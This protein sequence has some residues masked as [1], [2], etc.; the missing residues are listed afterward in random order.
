[1]QLTIA[2]MNLQS[3]VATTK[4]GWHYALSGWKYWLPHSDWP[5]RA[6]GKML[7]EENVDIACITEISEKSLC[8]G[9][10]SQVDILSKSAEIDN[11]CFFSTKVPFDTLRD[12]GNAIFSKH[13]IISSVS[14][15]LHKELFGASLDEAIIE[16]ENPQGQSAKKISVLVAHLALT[17]KNREIQIKEIIEILKGKEGLIILAG[18]FN[19]RN[20]SALDIL[21]KE[22]P[23]KNKC[24]LPTFPSWNPKQSFDYIFLSKE[25]SVT[26]CHIQ[27][28][29]P[30]SDHLALMVNTELD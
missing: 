29:P 9:F 7:K 14:H 19:E 22:T 23:L 13:R 12:E 10:K 20:P 21:L 30:F 8:T 17:K 5:I 1:M 6:A 25:F 28:S 24:T 2:A 3:G 15:P 4:G 27:K 18:D 11:R 26:D 16:V